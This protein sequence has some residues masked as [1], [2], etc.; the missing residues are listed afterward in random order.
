MKKTGD[1]PSATCTLISFLKD[2]FDKSYH[3]MLYIV[4]FSLRTKL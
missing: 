3:K 2:E 4:F 1:T